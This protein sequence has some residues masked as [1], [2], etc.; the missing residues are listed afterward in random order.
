M[1][2]V[3]GR[4]RKQAQRVCQIAL[5][6][7]SLAQAS[8]LTPLG[9]RRRAGLLSLQAE[10]VLAGSTLIYRVP[11]GH[12]HSA[13]CWRDGVQDQREKEEV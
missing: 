2:A 9:Q 12:S 4:K 10:V 8:H 1:A 13:R 3:R 11:D 7:H 5:T 6:R